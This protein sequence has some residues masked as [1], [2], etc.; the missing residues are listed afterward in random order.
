VGQDAEVSAKTTPASELERLY[1]EHGD[2]LWRAVC[3]YAGDAGVA[4]DA[5][6]E[7]LA[8]AM[9]RGSELRDPLRWLWRAVFRIAAGELK[10][11]RG[12]VSDA[13]MG[14]PQPA[15]T[16][17]FAVADEIRDLMIALT[18]I[19]SSQRQALILHHY[20]EFSV[21]EIARVMAT[22]SAAVKMHLSRGR[23]R[24]RS[25]LEDDDA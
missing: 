21:K 25:L 14:R 24:L 15:A 2:R 12:R 23:H 3:A 9:R 4:D 5:V 1:R 16:D 18:K 7:A 13:P 22:T 17:A 20:A 11:R 19:S 6:A 10:A 8:Q